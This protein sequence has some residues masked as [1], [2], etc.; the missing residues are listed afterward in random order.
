VGWGWFS[1]RPK[2][3]EE[4]VRRATGGDRRAAEALAERLLPVV[5]KRV[6][7]VLS[8]KAAG[9]REDVL[10]YTQDALVRLF[11]Q[12]GRILK[13]WDPARGASLETFAGLVAEREVLTALRSGRRS[14][15][16]EDPTLDV[17]LE[18]KVE[19]PDLEER[20]GDRAV[21]ERLLDHLEVELTPRARGLFV[22]LYVEDQAPEEV[23]ARYG[24]SLNALYS[25][26][27]RFKSRVDVWLKEEE[28]R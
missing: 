1:G 15:W 20:L 13:T 21:L 5:Q 16:R 18:R 7:W 2:S 10:D 17:E 8:R 9:R 24:M 11:E 22:S 27:S 3:D 4:W 26:R 12:E 14:A 19:G 28:G 23:A 25:W 6:A